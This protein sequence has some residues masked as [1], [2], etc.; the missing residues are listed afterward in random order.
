MAKFNSANAVLDLAGAISIKNLNIAED[1]T[2]E[3]S[4]WHL[5]NGLIVL[6]LSAGTDAV[7]SQDFERSLSQLK[8]QYNCLIIVFPTLPKGLAASLASRKIVEKI[9]IIATPRA[10][11]RENAERMKSILNRILAKKPMLICD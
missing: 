4:G 9:L 3:F 1:V 5:Q 6:R 8:A 2:A 10:C 11:L 7:F